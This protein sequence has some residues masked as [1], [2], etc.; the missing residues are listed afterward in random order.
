[1]ITVLGIDTNKNLVYVNDSAWE[2]EKGGLSSTPARLE[3]L[4]RRQIRSTAQ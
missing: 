4:H 2:Q 1:L 3:V